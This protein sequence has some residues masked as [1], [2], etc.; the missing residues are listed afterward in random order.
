MDENLFP[1]TT[2]IEAINIKR[3]TATTS[4][5]QQKQEEIITN[6]KNIT[7]GTDEIDNNHEIVANLPIRNTKQT[8]RMQNPK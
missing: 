4:N 2:N 5:T 1:E 3:N 8:V 6:K 7:T